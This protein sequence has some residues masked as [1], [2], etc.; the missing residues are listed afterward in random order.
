V[1]YGASHLNEPRMMT[2]RQ[3]R[4]V[5]WSLW[6]NSIAATRIFDSETHISKIYDKCAML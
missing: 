6:N 4:D 5:F 2:I 1:D 3:L